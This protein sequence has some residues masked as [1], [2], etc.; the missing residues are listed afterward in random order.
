MTQKV[1]FEFCRT[2]P[3]MGFFGVVNGR[4]CYCT[5]YFKPMESDSSQCDAVCEGEKTHVRRKIQEL[6]LR[7]AHVRQH[8]GRCCNQVWHRWI[9]KGKHGCQGEDREGP[10]HRHAEHS[11]QAPESL[12]SSW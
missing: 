8:Q 1:C 10:L 11:S 5:P 6:C 4:G 12:R 9:S 3:N 7:H 2:V